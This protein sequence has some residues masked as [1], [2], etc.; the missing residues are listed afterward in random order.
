MTVIAEF[1]KPK[2]CE[3]CPCF[4]ATEGAFSDECQLTHKKIENYFV[5]DKDCPLKQK[6]GIN[7]KTKQNDHA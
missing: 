5:V 2:K 7:E 4:Y 6:G 1:E 3:D